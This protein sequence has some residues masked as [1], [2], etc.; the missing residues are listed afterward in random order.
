MLGNSK[1]ERW[2]NEGHISDYCIS[3]PVIVGNW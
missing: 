2:P 1:E 3:D